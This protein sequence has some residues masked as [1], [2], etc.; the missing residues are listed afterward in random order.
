MDKTVEYYLGLPYTI[1]LIP[2]PE[3][4]WFVGVKELAGCISQGDTPQEAIDV[5]QAW[6][7]VSLESGDLISEPRPLEDYSGKFVV[8]VPRSLHQDLVEKAQQEGT[9]L[10]RYVNVSLARSVGLVTSVGPVASEEPSWPGLRASVRRALLAAGL[11]E[12][13]GELDEQLFANQLDPLIA[14]VESAV[15]RGYFRD[16]IWAIEAMAHSL[17]S[18]LEKSPVLGVFYRTVLL[19]R[20]QVDTLA[21]PRQP[22]D[23]STTG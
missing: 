1:E 15:E 6:V 10:N 18:A 17:R 21:E 3:G 19:L 22:V 12:E 2:E 16:A 20:S 14:Q 8:R 9:S 5:M 7:E 4:G 13:A 11:T 23:S